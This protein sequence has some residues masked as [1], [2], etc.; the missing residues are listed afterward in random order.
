M[1]QKFDWFSTHLILEETWFQLFADIKVRVILRIIGEAPVVRLTIYFLMKHNFVCNV[2]YGFN[3]ERYNNLKD[4]RYPL[5][6]FDNCMLCNHSD[7]LLL[8]L[9]NFSSR[10]L[11]PLIISQI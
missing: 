2:Q 3:S 6:F 9:L 7:F 8:N 5:Y 10:K 11:E 4:I 1:S